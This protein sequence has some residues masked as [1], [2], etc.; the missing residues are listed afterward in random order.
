MQQVFVCC[1]SS[2]IS[3]GV[4]D[5]FAALAE[6]VG[7]PRSEEYTIDQ[8]ETKQQRLVTAKR[9][10]DETFEWASFVSRDHFPHW[11]KYD[12]MKFHRGVHILR[13]RT[14]AHRSGRAGIPRL[15]P[16]QS[17]SLLGY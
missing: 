2:H 3:N 12:W 14:T 10:P 9:V 17:S 4:L 7:Q 11:G 15:S 5:S 16:S 8:D 6:H 1:S 13:G